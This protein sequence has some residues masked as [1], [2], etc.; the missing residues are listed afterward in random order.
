RAMRDHGSVSRR[1]REPDGVE[2]LRDGADLIQ[3]DEDRVGD[4]AGDAVGKALLVR[5]E[6]V[7]ADELDLFAELVGQELPAV[8]IVLRDPVLDRD[9]GVLVAEAR[10]DADEL[11]G[12]PW[13]LIERVTAVG[14]KFARRGVEAE[15]Y[16]LARLVARVLDRFQD[17]LKS[18]FVRAE[19]RGESAL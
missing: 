19:P 13:L 2:R 17:A 1:G 8:P 5:D 4:A 9:D 3:L 18:F 7:V 11:R 12:G 16:L 15:R 14:V 10:V 6:E